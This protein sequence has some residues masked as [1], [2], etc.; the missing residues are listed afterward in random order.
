MPF[1]DDHTQAQFVT[2]YEVGVSTIR[3]LKDIFPHIPIIAL[4]NTSHADLKRLHRFIESVP[5]YS[6]PIYS[7]EYLDLVGLHLENPTASILQ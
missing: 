4:S 5:T 1:S 2:S 6:K 3:E 7:Q